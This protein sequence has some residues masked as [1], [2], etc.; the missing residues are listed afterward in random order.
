MR[1]SPA[2]REFFHPPIVVGPTCLFR[3]FTMSIDVNSYKRQGRGDSH[4]ISHRFR[5][6][7]S[8]PLLRGVNC[9]RDESSGVRDPNCRQF[10]ALLPCLNSSKRRL[11][12][13]ILTVVVVGPSCPPPGRAKRL[14][15]EVLKEGTERVPEEGGRERSSRKRS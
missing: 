7:L 4:P 10:S 12:I 3:I 2:G 9:Y 8:S 5:T 11:E 14:Q 15:E 1:F 6:L 13:G